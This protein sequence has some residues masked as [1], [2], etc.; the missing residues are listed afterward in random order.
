MINDRCALITACRSGWQSGV[1]RT[2]TLLT[3]AV[4]EDR[5]T[6]IVTKLVNQ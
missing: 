4:A 5:V 3:R 1:G 2:A 6:K